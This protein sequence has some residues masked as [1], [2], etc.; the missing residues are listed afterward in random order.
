MH[1]KKLFRIASALL[2]LCLLS[3]SFVGST[4]A[5]YVSQSQGGDVARVAAWPGV[6]VSGYLF[7]KA[8]EKK[9]NESSSNEIVF[10]SDTVTI[11]AIADADVVGPGT[12]NSTGMTISITGKSETSANLHFSYKDHGQIM[13]QMSAPK[14]DTP[15][16]FSNAHAE[17]LGFI[18]YVGNE[19]ARKTYCE[20]LG[21]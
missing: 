10:N 19:A 12:K 21:P 18:G 8:Y 4:F 1:P 11:K 15:T 7:D 16:N 2:G 20:S 13:L 6:T 17:K 14:N 9:S 3:T 5:K